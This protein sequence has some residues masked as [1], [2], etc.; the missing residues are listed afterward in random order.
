MVVCP[1]FFDVCVAR[2]VFADRPCAPAVS[3]CLTCNPATTTA[4]AIGAA[5]EMVGLFF[6]CLWFSIYLD[7]LTSY[8]RAFGRVWL[9]FVSASSRRCHCQEFTKTSRLHCRRHCLFSVYLDQVK[10]NVYKDVLLGVAV[11]LV[12]CSPF[13]ALL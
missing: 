5:L 3:K 10:V 4:T 6:V 9:L 11:R 1:I 8:P 2:L 12:A 7:F 13:A